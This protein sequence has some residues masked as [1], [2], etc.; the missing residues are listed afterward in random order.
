[1]HRREAPV[2]QCRGGCGRTRRTWRETFLCRFCLLAD[3]LA[4]PESFRASARRI[5][6]RCVVCGGPYPDGS[7]C[8]F[9]PKVGVASEGGEAVEQASY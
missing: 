5:N 4:S 2:R 7:G 1:M 8:E 9:C 3:R 6:G